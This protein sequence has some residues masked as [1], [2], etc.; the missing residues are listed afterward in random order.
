MRYEVSI[1]QL[2]VGERMDAL[3]GMDKQPK[4]ECE[5]TMEDLK[6]E[7]EQIDERL[8]HCTVEIEAIQAF[9]YGLKLDE[10]LLSD[11]R[12]WL[13]D[14]ERT[15]NFLLRYMQRAFNDQGGF[16]LTKDNAI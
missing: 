3:S 16:D 12:H 1:I 8:S 10:D 14:V 6:K 2:F 11:I 5:G 15:T 7:A 9:L 4:L 13:E